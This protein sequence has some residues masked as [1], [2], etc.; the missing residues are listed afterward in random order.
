MIETHEG[1]TQY[2]HSLDHAL[3]FFSKA[4][5]LF[6]KKQSF[7]SGEESALSLFQKVW[8]VDE[9]TAFKLLLWL[10]DCR[11]GAGNRSGFRSCLNWLAELDNDSARWI[12]QNIDWVPE[13]GR[14]D[15]LRVLFNTVVEKNAV[16][17]WS[18]AIKENNVLAAKWADRKDKPLKHELGFKEEGKFRQYLAKIRKNHIVEHK[19]STKR[20]N[21]IDYHTVPSLAMARY[22]NA[23]SKNDPERFANY[24]EQLKSGE[25]SVHADVL[26]PHDCVRTAKNGD[27]EIANAQFDALPNYMGDEKAIVICDTSGSMGSRVAGSIE[28]V[29]VSQGLAL[30]CSA[31]IPEDNPFHKKFIG[32]CNEERFVDWNGNSFSDAIFDRDIFDGAVGSTQIDKALDGILKMASFF[33]ISQEHMPSM[34]IV[35]SDMQFHEGTDPNMT[36]M[37]MR[38]ENRPNYKPETEINKALKRWKERGYEPP[39][40]IYWNVAGYAGS[41]DTKYGKNIALVS[42]FSPA[43]LKAIFEGDDLTPLGVMKRALEKY[44]VKKPE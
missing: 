10:R 35:V 12:I 6:E 5:S 24:K 21:E 25:S 31:K 38:N 39:K 26:F 43:I 16:E 15:D 11:G 19:M 18:N 4:G 27:K 14:W 42:G 29:D 32:F 40:I 22:T 34:L 36:I 9:E 28:A 41:P 3:E 8:I 23:F 30:Y 20:W 7:Y 13:V 33:N 2:E 17:L 1:G 44:Q 37:R